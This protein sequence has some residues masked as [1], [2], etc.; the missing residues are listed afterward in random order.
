[1]ASTWRDLAV[2]SDAVRRVLGLPEC[3]ALGWSVGRDDTVALLVA[4]TLYVG[5]DS[6]TLRSLSPARRR[7]LRALE[8]LADELAEVVVA[9]ERGRQ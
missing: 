3:D 8:D 2:I 5:R 7:A 1:M 4:E 9:S 6:R